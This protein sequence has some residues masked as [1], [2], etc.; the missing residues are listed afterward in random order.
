MSLAP[1]RLR[2]FRH[3]LAAYGVNQL[4]DWAG[5][6]AIAVA[7]YRTTGSA[8]AVAATWVVHRCLLAL[9]APALV[10]RLEHCRTERV[11]PGIYLT[12][13]AI[14]AGLA[15]ASP[16]AGLAA[17]LPLLALDG[18]LAP[19]ARALTRS[20]VVAV[21]HP[22]GLHREGNALINVVFT[23]N[24]IVAPAIGGILVATTGP[25]SAL[26]IDAASFVLAA[27]AL[28]TAS[29]PDHGTQ[30]SPRATAARA[31]A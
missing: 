23:T 15:V 13:A 30:R 12:Q 20:A 4:G 14:F 19:T 9:V 26:L 17:I 25:A 31:T 8:A 7:V 21:T 28:G 27:G 24:G 11:L 5:E 16:R 2:P 29:L 6:V 18:M 1:L 22:A 3:L 10:A